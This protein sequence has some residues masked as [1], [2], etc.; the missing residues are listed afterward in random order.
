MFTFGLLCFTS[1]FTLI[2]PLGAMPVF[3]TMTMELDEK[4]RRKVAR[5]ASLVSF[6]I[7]M[8]FAISGDLLFRFFGISIDSAD[9]RRNHLLDYGDGYVAGPFGENQGERI[10]SEELC[11]RYLDH[12]FIYSDVMWPWCDYQRNRY[13]EQSYRLGNQNDY[14]HRRSC[15]DYFGISYFKKFLPD[16]QDTRRNRQ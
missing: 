8:F 7:M 3:M 13:V 9:C 12:A 15:G 6:L 1:F 11:Q 2:N 16:Y 10:G 5:R 4:E 14:G